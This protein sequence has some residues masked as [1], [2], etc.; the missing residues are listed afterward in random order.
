MKRLIEAIEARIAKLRR[1]GHD[2]V[3]LTDELLDPLTQLRLAD[4]L[5]QIKQ[6]AIA[7]QAR[8]IKELESLPEQ[9]SVPEWIDRRDVMKIIKGE[10]T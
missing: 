8:L 10:E 3:I 6:L 4:Y 7:E 5:E 1:N 9:D 2:G